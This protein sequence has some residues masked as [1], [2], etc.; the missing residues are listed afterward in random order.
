MN[1][2]VLYETHMHT[3]L[4]NH[5]YGEPEEYAS[6][7]L[8]RGLKGITVTCHCPLPDKIS[9][10]I[11]MTPDE[12]DA[13]VAMVERAR[14]AFEGKLDVRL[15]IESDFLPGLEPWLEKLHQRSDL[16]YV[17]GSVH[18]HM[19][20]Y[21]ERYLRWDWPAFHRQYFDSLAEAAETG[22]FD[23]ISHPDIV[24]NQ[25]TEHWNLEALMPHIE[26]KLDRIAETGLAMELNTSGLQKTL[27][28][29][30][31]APEI[32]AAMKKRGIPVVIGADAHVPERV[33]DDYEDALRLLQTIGYTEVRYFL[34]RKPIDVPIKPALESLSGA[35]SS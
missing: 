18:P 21:K 12:W 25:G 22:L 32:L 20:E 17:L 33:A 19:Q 16:D 1:S 15:G 7:A 6:V 4:C 24:K 28:E 31:P 27:P 9:Y 30:N 2:R 14:K 34:E 29:M 13:Y 10:A 23:C 5:A 3:P 8:R 26:S 11:R 35:V